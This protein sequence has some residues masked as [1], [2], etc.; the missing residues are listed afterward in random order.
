MNLIVRVV[1]MKGTCPVYKVGDTFKL[2]DEYKLV[3][4]I[5][6]CIH[7]LDAA[8]RCSTGFQIGD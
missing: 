4:E 2:E 8:L 6:L 3:S 7:S 1:E 5:P